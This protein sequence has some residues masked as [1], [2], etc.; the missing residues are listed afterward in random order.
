VRR[1]LG[2]ENAARLGTRTA[3]IVG[4]G[5]LGSAVASY[6]VRAGIGKLR[7]VD[8]DVV[9]ETNLGDQALYLDRHAR[10]L[11]PK[12]EAAAEQLA[13]INSTVAVESLVSM[14][15]R[16]SAHASVSGVD[17]IIDGADNLDTKYL[18]NDVA[19]AT[20]TPWVYGGCVGSHGSVLAVIPRVTPCLRCMWPDPPPLAGT[21]SCAAIGLLPT[22]P[23]F[24]A[25]LQATAAIQI[26]VGRP[27]EIHGPLFVDIAGAM[28][29]HLNTE[30]NAV[31]RDDCRAC[32][33]GE[34]DFLYGGRSIPDGGSWPPGFGL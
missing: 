28:I 13:L 9:H 12:V 26:L 20:G 14:F 24:V 21:G 17:I 8:F 33:L 29:R 5:A 3:L 18:L 30:T 11:T 25:A 2:D 23:G 1:Y 19:V 4:C 15:D 34:F 10:D 16:D 27:G 32:A 7:L 22:T 6:L 31:R